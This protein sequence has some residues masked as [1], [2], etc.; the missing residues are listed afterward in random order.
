MVRLLIKARDKKQKAEAATTAAR[1]FK[2]KYWK[3]ALPW[4]YSYHTD[5]GVLL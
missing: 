3:I 1:P 5:F 4:V 2:R